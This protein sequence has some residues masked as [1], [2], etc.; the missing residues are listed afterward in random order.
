VFAC[1]ELDICSEIGITGIPRG[2]K[3]VLWGSHGDRNKCRGTLADKESVQ[4]SHR[5]VALTFLHPSSSKSES[6]DTLF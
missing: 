3:L 1:F 2:R 4:D 6:A 5:N